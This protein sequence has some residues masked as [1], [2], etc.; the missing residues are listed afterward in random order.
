MQSRSV[1][2][3]PLVLIERQRYFSHARGADLA[4]IEFRAPGDRGAFLMIQRISPNPRRAFR[5]RLAFH[6]PP[7]LISQ[8]SR[9]IVSLPLSGE[10]PWQ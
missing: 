8:F 9:T 6:G 1:I 4:L 2:G 3:R 10:L 5:S 7:L